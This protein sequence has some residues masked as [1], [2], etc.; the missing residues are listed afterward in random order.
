[1]FTG[2]SRET[3]DYFIQISLE[4]SKQK[5]LE[6][7]PVYE[8]AVKAPLRELYETLL[9]GLLPVAPDV[10]ARASRCVSGA[11]NDARFSP[12][13]PMKNYVYLHFMQD[14]AR[15]NDVPGFFFDAGADGWRCGLQLYHRTTAGMRAVNEHAKANEA[16][17][18]SVLR[19]LP[20]A[21]VFEGDRYKRD[22][23]DGMDDP[24]R[25][26]LLCKRIALVYAP[27]AP[28][29]FFTPGLADEIT[30]VFTACA[31]LYAWLRAALC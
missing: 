8:R 26:F 20:S 30:R 25:D 18:Q 29:A 1:M 14:T 4:N 21:L 24:A 5:Y 13:T 12:V 17:L 9:P 3:I 23:S 31:P 28:D 15:E 6:L 22:R 7:K 27:K 16:A 2:F 11:Y 10:C 19:A